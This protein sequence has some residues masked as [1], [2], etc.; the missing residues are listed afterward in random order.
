MILDFYKQLFKFNTKKANDMISDEF[1]CTIYGHGEYKGREGLSQM[2]AD[3]RTTT[4][5]SLTLTIVITHGKHAAANGEV[6]MSDGSKMA[7][8]EFFIFTSHSKKAKILR[9]D[10]YVVAVD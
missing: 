6:V 3:M 1:V 4:T 10:S 9:Q 2:I 5:V 8:A 7:F